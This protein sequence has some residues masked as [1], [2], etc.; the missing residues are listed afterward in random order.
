MEQFET[1]LGKVL[2]WLT[3]SVD[4]DL[5]GIV[6]EEKTAKLDNGR[7]RTKV[8]IILAI[9]SRIIK[10][11]STS[12]ETSRIEI[13]AELEEIKPIS[14]VIGLREA[15]TAVEQVKQ[16]LDAHMKL[17]GGESP[18]ADAAF[19]TSIAS[20][21]IMGPTEISDIRTVLKMLPANTKWN[22]YRQKAI[23]QLLQELPASR[24]NVKYA[25]RA[26]ELE[27]SNVALP[28][29]PRSPSRDPYQRM[30]S[31]REPDKKCY[32]WSAKGS[33]MRG[34]NCKFRHGDTDRRPG[35]GKSPSK[36]RTNAGAGT[37]PRGG[38]TW[39]KTK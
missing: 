25:N 6:R 36:D 16:R 18:A 24:E 19:K 2:Q 22:V 38:L 4:S 39:G 20:R 33:C 29:F 37:T 31:P 13:L 14:T 26:R 23:E 7:G 3:V 30:P 17:F 27:M 8:T 12:P 34:D 5:Q 35:F 32:E 10:D 1:K 15:L 21:I 28:A 11:L 9:R